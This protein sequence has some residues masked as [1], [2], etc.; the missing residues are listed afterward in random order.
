MIHEI[1]DIMAKLREKRKESREY[2]KSLFGCIDEVKECPSELELTEDE[3]KVLQEVKRQ[4]K[5]P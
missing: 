3:I 1:N 2:Y 4:S 5:Q